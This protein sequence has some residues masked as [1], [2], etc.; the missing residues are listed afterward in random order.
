MDM[1]SI[2]SEVIISRRFIL[3][4]SFF[5]FVFLVFLWFLFSFVN[6]VQ[7]APE[8]FNEIVPGKS[9]KED[10]LKSE[11][12]PQISETDQDLGRLLYKS[13]ET[14]YFDNVWEKDG[15][16]ILT[17]ENVFKNFDL[18]SY[19]QKY[20]TP[21]LTLFDGNMEDAKWYVYLTKGVAFEA[22]SARVFT[23]VKFTPQNKEEF[24]KDIAPIIKARETEIKEV[25]EFGDNP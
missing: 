1:N 15:K 10:V 21:E 12:T 4:A 6:Y 14:Y 5:T 18:S 19:L 17:Q 2:D 20:G 11:G 8:R 3:F 13:G 16:V 25:R 23:L 22:N 24:L 9:T 7:I